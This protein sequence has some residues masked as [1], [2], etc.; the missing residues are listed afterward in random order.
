MQTIAIGNPGVCCANTAERI[1]DLFVVETRGAQ[2]TMYRTRVQFSLHGF[3]A[4]FAILL[5]MIKD[6]IYIL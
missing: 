3:D 1:E 4:A 6:N 5:V 2:G